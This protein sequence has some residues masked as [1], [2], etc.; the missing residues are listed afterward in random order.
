MIFVIYLIALEANV[1]PD[2]YKSCLARAQKALSSG[3]F[4][5]TTVHLMEED[6]GSTLPTLH[7]FNSSSGPLYQDVKDLLCAWVVARSDEGLGYVIG[8]SKIAAMLLLNMS[9]P[10]AFVAMRNL[11]E[12]HCLRSFYG[13]LSA[14]DDVRDLFKLSAY[15]V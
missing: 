10:T 8:A 1:P 6:I 4:P 2:T 9:A 3:S 14:R 7:I 11:L 5:S 15:K 13:G 12:R